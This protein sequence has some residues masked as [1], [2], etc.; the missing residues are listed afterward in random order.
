MY[1]KGLTS[2]SRQ[3][4]PLMTFCCN[5]LWTPTAALVTLVGAGISKP[6]DQA[7]SVSVTTHEKLKSQLLSLT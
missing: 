3:E 2:P 1:P 6:T 7:H 4:V 5:K